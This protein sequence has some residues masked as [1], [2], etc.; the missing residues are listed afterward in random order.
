MCN[1]EELAEIL[2]FQN[3]P[4]HIG[5]TNQDFSLDIFQ[6]MLWESCL[7]CGLIQL[8]NLPDPEL[9]YV[10]QSTVFAVGQT[11]QTHHRAFAKFI[12]NLD[13]ISVLEIGGAHGV[14][15][16]EYQAL[17]PN[18]IP[19]R[20]VEPNP[21]PVSECHAIYIPEFFEESGIEF[22]ATDLIVH[23]HVLEHALNPKHFLNLA[24]SKMEKEQVMAVSIPNLWS[25]LKMGHPNALNFEH[26][27]LLTE[28]LAESLFESVGLQ[29]LNKEYF[30]ETHSI[31]YAL[32]NK[33][34]LPKNSNFKPDKNPINFFKSNYEK[35]LNFVRTC[36]EALIK[37]SGEAFIFGGSIFAQ[38]LINLGL[39]TDFIS[40]I[41]DNDPNK[42]GKRLYGS[43]LFI[44][45]AKIVGELSSPLIIIDCGEYN[46]E[47]QNQIV[48]INKK[49]RVMVFNSISLYSDI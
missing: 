11:W 47:I 41:L 6:D 49:A 18:K 48:S 39:N 40:S 10:E 27:Y 24:V 35:K 1:G 29:I 32:K 3:F 12:Q 44:E 14:L 43:T 28:S 22:Y 2:R 5:A 25:W 36:N 38:Q 4:I 46:L 26:S 21:S 20:I 31:F 17:Q 8:K 7:D 16:V 23:S 45:S 42:H 30:A 9:V 19:W 34:V 37:N 15:S 33:V 13:P